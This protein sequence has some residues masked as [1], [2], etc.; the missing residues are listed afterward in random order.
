MILQ[1]ISEIIINEILKLSC[2]KSYDFANDLYKITIKF[3]YLWILWKYV[4]RN[5]LY[6][7]NK[8][9]KFWLFASKWCVLNV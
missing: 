3:N 9:I 1:K 8:F 4:Q 2:K 6:N 7:R 5:Y